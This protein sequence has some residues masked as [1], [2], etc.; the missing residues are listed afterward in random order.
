MFSGL[1]NELMHQK[2]KVFGN[3]YSC[4]NIGETLNVSR[5]SS[6]QLSLE[7]CRDLMKKTGRI[8]Q[9]N[10]LKNNILILDEEN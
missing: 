8:F 2:S 6:P 7:E 3:L 10:N 1:C 9:T 5:K 4:T